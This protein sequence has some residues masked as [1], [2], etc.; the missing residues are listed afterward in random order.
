MKMIIIST[1]LVANNVG[2]KQM[3]AGTLRVHF[4]CGLKVRQEVIR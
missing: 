3:A 2:T 1:D 4:I